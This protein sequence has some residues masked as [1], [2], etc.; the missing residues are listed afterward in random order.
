MQ[1]YQT[2]MVNH[3][4]RLNNSPPYFFEM[5]NRQRLYVIIIIAGIAFPVASVA[6]K[7]LQEVYGQGQGESGEFQ[8]DVDAVKN[9]T[10][11]L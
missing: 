9:A 10:D 2:T 4:M 1:K 3:L 6:I 7:V 11:P 5:N 8:C